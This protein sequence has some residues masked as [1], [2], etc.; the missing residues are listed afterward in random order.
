MITLTKEE[1]FWSKVH[2]TDTCWVWIGSTDSRGYGLFWWDGKTTRA[3]RYS[4]MLYSGRPIPNS[5]V[6][7]CHTCDHTY[8]VNPEHL[9][10]G[11][12]TD[13]MRD[14]VGKCRNRRNLKKLITE[15][16]AREIVVEY[17]SGSTYTTLSA[18]YN[19][20]IAS[21]RRIIDGKVYNGVGGRKRA[22]R[23]SSGEKHHTS[24][25][26]SEIVRQMRI[27]YTTGS[28]S[29]HE[30]ARRHDVDWTTIRDAVNGTTW[31]DVG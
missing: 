13:N 18:K 14:M 24:K 3:T 23:F 6:F 2:K 5:R 11:T 1:A 4:W 12:H 31:A 16:Q 7:V 15:R 8:C 29:Y 22:R 27:D 21:I 25:L 9:F 10:L 19:V 20:S 17:N 26:T 28:I 30:L